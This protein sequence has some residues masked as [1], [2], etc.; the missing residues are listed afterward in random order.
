M[1][2][3]LI[4]VIIP[5]YNREK[6]IERAVESA[7]NQSYKNFEIIIIDDS[8]GDKTKKIIQLLNRDE[9]KYI[10]NETKLGFVK[11]L[12]KGIEAAK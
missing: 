11:S 1:E 12:N 7:L 5:T 3:P 4:S 6:Y 8:E 2:Q 10:K 9:I